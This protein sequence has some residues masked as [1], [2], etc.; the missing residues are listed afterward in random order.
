MDS[1]LWS[2]STATM[3]TFRVLPPR[4]AISSL[5]VLRWRDFRISMRSGIRLERSSQ[6]S[7]ALNMSL[8]SLSLIFDSTVI[9]SVSGIGG[10]G[11]EEEEERQR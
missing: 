2:L 5:R 11:E 10:G 4:V 8:P 7:N 6:H 3:R 9:S 1:M